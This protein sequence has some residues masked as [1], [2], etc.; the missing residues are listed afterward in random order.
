MKTLRDLLRDKRFAF[1]FTVAIIL[2]I[3]SL[4]SFVSPYDPTRWNVVPRDLSPQWPHILGTNS[5]GQDVFWLLCFAVRNS[6]ILSLIAALMSRI[7][8]VIVGMVAGYRGGTVD[9]VLM[10]FT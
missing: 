10:F 5:M 4:L 1:G 3:L 6:L 9:R 7:I 8:A 2:V